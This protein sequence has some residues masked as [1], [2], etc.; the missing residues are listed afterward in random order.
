ML[1]ATVA[2]TQSGDMR[3]S[4][5]LL[6]LTAALFAQQDAPSRPRSGGERA[7]RVGSVEFT[8]NDLLA[9]TDRK[10]PFRFH[11]KPDSAQ[12]QQARRDALRSLVERTLVLLDAKAR[13]LEASDAQIEAA[14]DHALEQAGSEY[15]SIDVATRSKLL[16]ENRDAVI[17]RVLVDANEARFANG[18]AAVTEDELRARYAERHADLLSPARARLLHL[19]VPVPPTA[20]DKEAAELRARAQKARD[21]IAGGRPFED[22]ARESSSDI[23]AQ[24]G[25]DLGVVERGTMR[26]REIEAAAFALQAGELSQVQLSMYGFH[27]VKCVESMPPR[28]LSFEEA[29]PLL[30]ETMRTESVEA[31]RAAW[32]RQLRTDH[33]VRVEDP[34]WAALQPPEWMSVDPGKAR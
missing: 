26:Y 1:D 33:P 25:G 18:I 21:A 4:A 24:Q 19:L 8:R 28:A 15:R 14:F 7:A 17:R 10:L 20:S 31:A 16:Q 29:A 23:Y 5:A 11:S 9:E 22:V 2:M 3:T 13:G 34:E 12:M 32:M 6:L 27:V 30:R